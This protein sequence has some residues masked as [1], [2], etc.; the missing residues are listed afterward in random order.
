VEEVKARWG[1]LGLRK[2]RGPVIFYCGTGWRSSISF[3]L[4]YLMG[5]EGK[6][7][8]SGW[9]GWSIGLDQADCRVCLTGCGCN[10]L[11][12]DKGFTVRA[13]K[14][15]GE[16]SGGEELCPEGRQPTATV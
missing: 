3:V 12:D 1:L 9:F 7:Y 8:D 10:I 4:A 2:E 6:N 13:L 16:E 15:G 14:D 11:K 5:W